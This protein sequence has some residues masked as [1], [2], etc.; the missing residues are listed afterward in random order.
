M[1]QLRHSW[2]ARF[3]PW[4]WRPGEPLPAPQPGQTDSTTGLRSYLEEIQA[5]FLRHFEMLITYLD[6][7]GVPRTSN[8]AERANRSWRAVARPRYGWGS[9]QGQRAMLIALQG[10]DSS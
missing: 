9:S 6:E 10:F 8:H 7:P 2:S 1:D 4:T 5:F 3:R